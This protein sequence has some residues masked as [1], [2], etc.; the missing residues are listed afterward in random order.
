MLFAVGLWC[1]GVSACELCYLGCLLLVGTL[2]L[3]FGFAGYMV[4]IVW[5]AI[6]V[7][8]C[9]F[10]GCWLLIV[11]VGCYVN[12]CWLGCLF[13]CM[14]FDGALWDFSGVVALELCGCRGCLTSVCLLWCDLFGVAIGDLLVVWFRLLCGLV[15]V[16][17]LFGVGW[18]VVVTLIW[19][20]ACSLVVW[21]GLERDWLLSCLLL[22]VCWLF[23]W[24][25]VW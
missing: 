25:V 13:S 2:M 4:V 5:F 6:A 11:V 9:C 22:I 19:Y 20:C 24:L 10:G 7:W 14:C 23:L 3:V 18:L 15:S 12:A 8:V 17:Y 1:A 16:G 21:G